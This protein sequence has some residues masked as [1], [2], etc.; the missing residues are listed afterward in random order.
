M[1]NSELTLHKALEKIDAFCPIKIIFNGI[2]L[3]NDY[4][5][6]V[7][8]EDGVWG[9]NDI[10]LNVIPNR[11]WQFDKYIVTSV[12][13]EIVEFHHAIITMQGEYKEDLKV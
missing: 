10:P 5:S 4:D 9:E 11:I 8:I 3:Y 13:I 2:I 1:A 7:E 6:D 12:N